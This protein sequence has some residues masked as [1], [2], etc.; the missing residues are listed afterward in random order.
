ME[1]EKSKAE[2]IIDAVNLILETLGNIDLSEAKT[3]DKVEI[4]ARL[5]RAEGHENDEQN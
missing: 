2:R 1:N 5:L 3:W 4:N